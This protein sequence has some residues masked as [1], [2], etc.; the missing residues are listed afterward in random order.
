MPLITDC[1]P[2]LHLNGDSQCFPLYYYEHR[3]SKTNSLFEANNI[4][5]DYLR[6]DAISDFIYE[7]SKNLY[8]TNVNKED[9]FYYVYGLLHSEDYRSAFSNDLKKSL[10]RLPL[11]DNSSDFWSFSKAGRDLADLH[12]NYETVKPY[13]K[14]TVTGTDNDNL[15]VHKI[16]FANK[17][18]KTTI[19]FNHAITISDIPLE[20]YEYVLNGK[21]AIEWI[22]DRYQVK[23]DEKTGIKNDPNDWAKERDQPRYILD[24]PLR[25]VTVSLETLKIVKSLPKLDLG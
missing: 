19:Q 1:L 10:P 16:R 14:V 18:D 11:V 21:S 13:D 23:T 17:D 6:K 15:L 20:A 4:D 7:Q 2:D 8:G 9:I 5:G 25:V 24:L 22:M 12:L 3:Q